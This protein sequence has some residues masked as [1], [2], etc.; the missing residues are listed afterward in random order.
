M[1]GGEHYRKP[2]RMNIDRPTPSGLIRIPGVPDSGDLVPGMAYFPGTGPPGATCGQCKWKG[3]IRTDTVRITW[4]GCE[5]F[6]KLTGRVGPEFINDTPACK[7]F[8]DFNAK[9]I[10]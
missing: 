1:G 3:Y 7:Y 4:R 10:P 8:E 9:K 6:K 2:G 5:K